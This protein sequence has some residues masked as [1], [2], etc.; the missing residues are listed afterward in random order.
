MQERYGGNICKKCRESDLGFR[1][2]DIDDKVIGTG[3]PNESKGRFWR[4]NGR[5]GIQRAISQPNE[6]CENVRIAEVG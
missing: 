3:C 1:P 5:K 2:I 6:L 4:R